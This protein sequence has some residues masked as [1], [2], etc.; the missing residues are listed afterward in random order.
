MEEDCDRGCEKKSAKTKSM[1]DNG[2]REKL[3]ERIDEECGKRA[4]RGKV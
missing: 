2:G 1:G 4:Q 3:V